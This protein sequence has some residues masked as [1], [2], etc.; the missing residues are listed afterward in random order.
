MTLNTQGAVEAARA[1]IEAQLRLEKFRSGELRIKTVLTVARYSFDQLEAVA[2][3]LATE[4]PGSMRP[5]TADCGHPGI[6][7]ADGLTYWQNNEDTVVICDDCLP[8]FKHL[9]ANR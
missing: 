9:M 5:C 1:S 8:V 2:V 3:L 4:E 7:T 6:V